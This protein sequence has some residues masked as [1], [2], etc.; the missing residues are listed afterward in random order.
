[1]EIINEIRNTEDYKNFK[2]IIDNLDD[3]IFKSDG[4]RVLLN[5]RKLILDFSDENY[6]KVFLYEKELRKIEDYCDKFFEC[7][8]N[9]FSYELGC[10][11]QK[12]KFDSIDNIRSEIRWLEKLISIYDEFYKEEIK[13][14]LDLIDDLNK[15]KKYCESFIEKDKLC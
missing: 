15:F 8:Q 3:L 2:E 14:I 10:K 13:I 7:S 1:M 5:T 6:M 12:I 11:Y 9:G 4:N